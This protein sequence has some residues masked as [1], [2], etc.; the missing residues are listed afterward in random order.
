MSSFAIKILIG[1]NIFLVMCA[2]LILGIA[3]YV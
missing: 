1:I 3:I 2:T